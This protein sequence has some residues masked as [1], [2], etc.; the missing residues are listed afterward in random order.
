MK[1]P[2]RRLAARPPARW[3][4]PVL[5]VRVALA[6]SIVVFAPGLL[7][8]FEAPKAEL[9]R[10]LGVGSLAALLVSARG[11]E[12]IRWQPLD[13]AVAAWLTVEVLSTLF[14]V[15]PRLSLLGEVRQ[16]EG[17]LTSLGLAGLYFAARWGATDIG[18]A[19]T[20]VQV[21]IAAATVAGLYALIQALGLDPLSWAGTATYGG[22]G[23]FVRPSG[24]LGHANLLG[25][26]SAAAFV[27]A[28]PLAVSGHHRRWLLAV[29]GMLLGAVTMLTLSR[30]AWLGAATGALVAG[31]LLGLARLDHR[32]RIKA[33]P[34]GTRG[35]RNE[36]L[37]GVALTATGIL[38]IYGIAG[39]MLRARF[40]E[41]LA[42]GGGSGRSRLEI[43]RMA[44][45]CWQARPW[46][47]H[48]PDT[49]ALVSP[50]YQTPE[51][52][53]FEWASVPLHAHSIYLHT[54]A[55][56]GVLGFM[57]GTAWAVTLL[58]AVRH[59]WRTSTEARVLLAALAG[60]LAAIGVAGAFGALG[61][62]GAAFVVVA[63][64]AVASL[65]Q[66]SAHRERPALSKTPDRRALLFGAVA[67]ALALF[68]SAGDLAASRA[69]FIA[70][71]RATLLAG[72]DLA[73]QRV[74]AADRAVTIRPMEDVFQWLRADTHL[75]FSA[76]SPGPEVAL[77][78]AE[79]SA[80]R[81][82]ALAPL[83][84]LN[85]QGLGRVLMMR[86][87][88]HEVSALPAG[89]AAY[90]RCLEL[91]P[92]DAL[93]MLQLAQLELTLGRPQAALP[94]ARRAA[95]L[96]PRIGLGQGLLA[97]AC[98]GVGDPMT[99]RRALEQAV[100]GD[101]LGLEAGRRQAMRMLDTLRTPDPPGR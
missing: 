5:W 88:R 49:L 24:T 56:R 59:A 82:I 54:L 7:E 98:L 51:Y 37:I 69:A 3:A 1:P 97:E 13:V 19:R 94:P 84:A 77:A 11:L 93:A 74:A 45:A 58:L 21:A 10:V 50:H 6:A 57:A 81:A 75:T 101:W 43:W 79:T 99:A 90:A 27:A 47:G 22:Q 35:R 72:P 20:T 23:A 31:T 28:L 92:Y 55:T 44:I 87:L 65:A 66:Q 71:G 70:Q 18:R 86:A 29:A 61:V 85:H 52:W 100:T 53:R 17:L 89:E 73:T 64:A 4:D 32:E 62:A 36:V 91:A 48:G 63:S 68:W 2:T 60:A 95:L 9:V 39:D 76:V 30:A 25:V 14:S 38:V 80:R 40:A 67:T 96:Y 46:L 42:P 26:V 78:E 41:L 8:Q 83:R 33:G 34:G 12:R 15:A 16:R